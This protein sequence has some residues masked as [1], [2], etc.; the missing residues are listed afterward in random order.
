MRVIKDAD[1]RK[2]EILDVAEELFNLNGFDAT[3]ISAIIEKAGIARGTVYYHFKSKEDVLDA[4]IERHCERLLAEAKEIAADSRLPVMERLIQTLM[5]M[6]GDK[7][8]TPSVITQQMHRPQNALMH[9]KTHETML[10]AIPPI[11]MGIIEDGIK[12][13]IFNTPYPYESL[14]MVVAHVNT[15][16]DDYA[17]KLTGKELLKRIRA[18][19]FNLERLFG[20]AP[21]S[22]D[23]VNALFN[24]GGGADE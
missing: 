20:A 17:E 18:F 9:Q 4:L 10:E 8:G 15:V 11:L 23:S 24:K 22:F 19:I 14:E 6:N 7:E 21:G 5:S 13:G 12:E 3:T 2:N 16:F 1:V